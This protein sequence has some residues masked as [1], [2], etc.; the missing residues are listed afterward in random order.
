MNSEETEERIAQLAEDMAAQYAISLEE[1][2]RRIREALRSVHPA[3]Y[4][5][6]TTDEA[7]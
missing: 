7:S 5:T 6:H 2:Q 3:R 1:A 4:P